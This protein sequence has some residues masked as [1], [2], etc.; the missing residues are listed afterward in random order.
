MFFL[1]NYSNY[2]KILLLPGLQ[3]RFQIERVSYLTA[4]VL[5]KLPES[6]YH[7]LVF[8]LLKV[9][10]NSLFINQWKM[11]KISTKQCAYKKVDLGA[12]GSL[13]CTEY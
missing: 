11:G 1:R 3:C 10:D 7:Y 4:L 12:K 6:V 9:T 13:K 8:I 2:A 5:G